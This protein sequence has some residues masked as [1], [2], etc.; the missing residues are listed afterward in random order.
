M[1]TKCAE[2]VR[3]I[4]MTQ[5]GGV[6]ELRLGVPGSVRLIRDG[7]EVHPSGTEQLPE[8]KKETT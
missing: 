3:L 1:C 2:T 5:D 7:K 6:V 4:E 8:G